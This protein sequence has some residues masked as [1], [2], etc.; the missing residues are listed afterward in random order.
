MHTQICLFFYLIQLISSLNLHFQNQLQRFIY[1]QATDTIVLAS[2]NHIYSLNASDLTILSHIDLS[3]SKTNQYCSKTN[4]TYLQKNRYFFST[5]SYLNTTNDNNVF[6]QILLPTSDN[7]ILI[8]STRNRGS[9]CELRSLVDLHLLKNSS[10]RLVSSSPFYPSIGLLSQQNQILYLSTTYDSQCDPFYEI[11]TL[12]GRRLID[13][14]FLSILNFKSGQSALQQ[15]TYT[16]RLLN[17]RLIKEFFLYYLYA[18]EYKHFSYFLT[19][20]QSDIHHLH[21][22]RLQ[23]K[24]IRFCQTL[25]Q[26]II[27][28]YMEIPLTCGENYHYLITAKFSQENQILYGLFRNTTLANLTSTSHAVCTY[29]IASIQQGFYQTMKRCLVDGK[30]YRGLGFL[31]PDTHCVS[32]KVCSKKFHNEEQNRKRNK[33]VFFSLKSLNDIHE[34]YCPDE[35]DSFFQYPIGGHRAIEQIQPIV[36]FHEKVNLTSIE[37]MKTDQDFIVFLGDDH[38]TVH[39]VMKF[40][41]KSNLFLLINLFFEK[42]FQFENFNAKEIL[43]QRFSSKIILDLQLIHQYPTRKNAQLLILTDDQVEIER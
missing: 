1:N 13:D 9:S 14:P 8:C 42:N 25:N 39:T 15:S 38:G 5:I 20:Q 31:S 24:I 7:S 33:N 17:T 6:N 26:P 4:Q 19:I 32:S 35:N 2:I 30:G 43:K 41:L 34:D 18:F 10:Q 28:S 23:T 40:P 12:T 11:P 21:K 29:S 22:H 16:L 27:K 36:E 3:L 37:I